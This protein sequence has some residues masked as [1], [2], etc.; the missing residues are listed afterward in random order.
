[1]PWVGLA[2]GVLCALLS[3]PLQ[4]LAEETNNPPMVADTV[5]EATNSQATLNAIQQLAQQLRSNQFA[6]EQQGREAEAA[7]KRQAELL[8]NGLAAIE[9]A[10]SAQREA[11][12]AGS[13]RELEALRSSNRTTLVVGGTFAAVASLAMLLIAWFQWRIGNVWTRISAAL[14]LANGADRGALLTAPAP[15]APAPVLSGPVTDANARLLGAMDQLERRVQQLEQCAT[16]T[17]KNGASAE[18]SGSNGELVPQP[19]NGGT[20]Q[21]PEPST[22]NDRARISTLLGEGKSLLKENAWEAAVARFDEVLALDPCHGEALV[23]K[24]AALERLQKLNEAFECYDR[25]IA[26]DQS[27]TIAYLHKGGLYNRLERFKEALEC[28]EKALKAQDDRRA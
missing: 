14:P 13:A 9:T 1:M 21:D 5:A 26:A 20:T 3:G 6:L 7:A 8:S 15:E 25:A 17:L 4:A 22:T 2:C 16:P 11:V 18:E 19:N 28:Y 27:M 12:A 23:K 10:L 24:G